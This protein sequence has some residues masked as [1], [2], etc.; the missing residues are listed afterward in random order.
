MWTP[1]MGRVFWVW[2]WLLVSAGVHVTVTAQTD[3]PTS[4]PTGP[5]CPASLGD[6]DW[7]VVSLV[8]HAPDS[9]CDRSTR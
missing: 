3:P 2:C 4:V 7:P 8:S 6:S 5:E 1:G 9:R